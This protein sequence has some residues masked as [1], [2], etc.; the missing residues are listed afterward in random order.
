LENFEKKVEKI[1]TIF[2]VILFS[3]TF[4]AYIVL[5][6]IA[7]L[8]IASAEK[9]LIFEEKNGFEDFEN[10]SKEI[11]EKKKFLKFPSSFP[12]FFSVI[13]FSDEFQ[14]DLSRKVFDL[15]S[16]KKM[17]L[18][19]AILDM[20]T[21]LNYYDSFEIENKDLYFSSLDYAKKILTSENLSIN[22]ISREKNVLQRKN[23]DLEKEVEEIKHLLLVKSLENSLVDAEKLL[24][25]FSSFKG[26]SKEVESIK[27]YQSEVKNLLSGKANE[28]NFLELKT[29]LENSVYSFIEAPAS[30]KLE[31]DKEYQEK[32]K[33]WIKEE[34]EKREKYKLGEAP[35]NPKEGTEKVIYVN[36]KTQRM[37]LYDQDELI[38]STP[39][40]S[41][42]SGFDTVKGDFKIYAKITNKHL[43]SPFTKD[44]ESPLYYDLLVKY[45]MPFFEGYGIHDA[46]WRSVYGGPDYAWSGSHGCINTPLDAVKFIWEWAEIGT[47][48]YID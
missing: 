8:K 3:L 32:R 19:L 9:K 24:N 18:N 2:F 36:L 48:V 29:F 7:N 25:Y 5:F 4:L 1:L 42:R 43:I 15:K 22:D 47:S 13:K 31:L 46:Y 35:K 16:S 33:K 41:G 12:E 6:G 10:F 21:K 11:S 45:W 37:Y 39:I 17:E 38:L 27:N 40:T 20:E 28:M 14:K 34:K 44:K 23:E 30:K 26:F